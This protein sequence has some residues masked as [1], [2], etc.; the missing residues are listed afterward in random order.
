MD[1]LGI[2]IMAAAAVF[3]WLLNRWQTR[4]RWD[5]LDWKEWRDQRQREDSTSDRR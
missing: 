3:L 2:A 4:W 1:P 5:Y